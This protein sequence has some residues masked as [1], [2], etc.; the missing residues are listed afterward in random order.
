MVATFWC[1]RHL[2]WAL[3]D[4]EEDGLAQGLEVGKFGPEYMCLLGYTESPLSPPPH[5]GNLEVLS[6]PLAA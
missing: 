5:T 2:G 4:G 1:E 6:P 3:E